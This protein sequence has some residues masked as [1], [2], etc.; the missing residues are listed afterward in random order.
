MS[1]NLRRV[2][3]PAQLEVFVEVQALH[4]D[5]LGHARLAD[6][7]RD[8]LLL[9]HAHR[10]VEL[11]RV[12]HVALGHFNHWRI[13][14]GRKLHN[15]GFLKAFPPEFVSGIS[16]GTGLGG[17]TG[18]GIY[19]LLSSIGL[20]FNYIVLVLIPFA[21]LYGATFHFILQLKAKIE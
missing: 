14:L 21:I 7:L 19:L 18:A 1:D 15:Y 10:K 16:S 20:T 4:Q 5:G 13:H 12:P 11:A 6:Q 3:F 2:R 17:I 9:L 8:L